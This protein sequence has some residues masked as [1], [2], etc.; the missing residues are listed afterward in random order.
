MESIA[1]GIQKTIDQFLYIV[2]V[3]CP[4]CGG[5]M[6]A[7]KEPPGKPPRAA[8][9]CM[10]CGY[11]SH[12]K[13]DSKKMQEIYEDSLK[14]KCINYLKYQSV[15]TNRSLLE[16][17]FDN[18]D[19]M[20]SETQSAKT[21]ASIVV[22]KILRSEPVHA[23]F[24]GK[25]GVGKSH[26]SMAILW[27]VIERSN[28]DKKCLF[29]SYYELLEQIKF[30]MNDREAQKAIMGTLM[31]E[32]KA[33]DVVVIDDI[34]SE[35]GMLTDSNVA[36]TDFNLRTLNGIMDARQDKPVIITTN[37]T[38]KQLTTMYGSRIVSRM[39]SHSNGLTVQMHETK[40]KRLQNTN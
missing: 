28:Y 10:S 14:A 32:I 31:S 26:I 11:K 4:E 24:T 36:V 21:T 6:H 27:E 40:D 8:P 1:V 38:G 29:I 33:A 16:S 39:L 25:T 9:V 34:G 35:V 17:R 19:V 7:W 22:S 12:Q 37:L 23:I 20:D 5:G 30:A 15:L 13:S 2:E 18:F 3:P